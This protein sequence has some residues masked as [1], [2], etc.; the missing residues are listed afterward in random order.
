MSRKGLG[1]RK[2]ASPLKAGTKS[3]ESSG[4][5]LRR[6]L[7]R[8]RFGLFGGWRLSRFHRLVPQ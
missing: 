5:Q 2:R 3:V 4:P 8:V 6:Q 7:G 1:P